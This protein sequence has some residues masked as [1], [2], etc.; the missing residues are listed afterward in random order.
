MP[1]ISQVI[2]P[3]D[4]LDRLSGLTR[5]IFETGSGIQPWKS[6]R[7]ERIRT[8]DPCNPIAV[9]YQTAPRPDIKPMNKP[10]DLTNRKDYC[11]SIKLILKEYQ[12]NTLVKYYAY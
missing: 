2:L 7:G 5:K 12:N 10:T 3:F 8:S 1:S 6:G 4:F 9:R 11:Y